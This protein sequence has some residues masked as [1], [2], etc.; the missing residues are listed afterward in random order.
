MQGNSKLFLFV[1]ATKYVETHK[2]PIDQSDFDKECGIGMY[3]ISP[4]ERDIEHANMIYRVQHYSGGAVHPCYKIYH[5]HCCGRMAKSELRPR[6]HEGDA[7]VA[8][9]QSA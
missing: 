2:V 1:A 3:H 6:W 8:M 5:F 9:G 4:F 7:G